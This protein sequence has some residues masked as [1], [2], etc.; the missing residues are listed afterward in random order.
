MSEGPG[1]PRQKVEDD[2]S[3]GD[4]GD[5]LRRKPGGIYEQKTDLNVESTRSRQGLDATDCGPGRDAKEGEENENIP[6]FRWTKYNSFPHSM[7]K[8]TSADAMYAHK[9]RSSAALNV[10]MTNEEL[11]QRLQEV[12]E[13]AEILRSELEVTQKQLEGK[14]EALKI[15]QS[16]AVLDKAIPHTKTLLQKTE[17]RNKILEKEVNVLQWEKEFNQDKHKN[18]KQ[19]YMQRYDRLC[20]ENAELAATVEARDAEIRDLKSENAILT[21][22]S[23]ELL[24]M[25]DVKDQQ[26]IRGLLSTSKNGFTEVTTLELGVLGACHCNSPGGEPC[27]CARMA[28]ATRKQL[29][30]MKQEIDVQRKRKEEA[31]VMSDAFRIA[32]EQQLKR[33]NDQTL[34][35]TKMTE[36]HR[37]DL[38]KGLTWNRLMEKEPVHK[39]PGIHSSL[40][41]RLKGLLNSSADIK[42]LEILDDPQEI[43]K[44]LV[45]LLNDKEEALA[46][47]RKVSYMLARRV[48]EQEQY[49]KQL[50]EQDGCRKETTAADCG[51]A[52]RRPERLHKSRNTCSSLVDQNPR[53]RVAISRTHSLPQ[54]NTQTVE[55]STET[56]QEERDNRNRGREFMEQ[57]VDTETKQED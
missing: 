19:S 7:H 25:L 48:E 43:L 14:Y 20:I 28:A 5:G 44:I 37:K 9:R 12:T 45:D 52:C 32:F 57:N 34:Q 54:I 40:G 41:Q 38:L 3:S 4:L 46:H 47:Q 6:C 50:K 30:Q 2:M 13:D 1:T 49:V 24:A 31:Y 17:E 33:T 36:L 51:K 42:K 26:M 10:E 11:K 53:R 35:M 29:L 8:L 23:S 56:L 18:F 39:K 55:G 27:T 15:L 21:Q 22:S 16:M